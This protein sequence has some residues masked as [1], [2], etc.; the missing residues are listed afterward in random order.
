MQ[1]L[2]I[3]SMVL[4]AA[5]CNGTLRNI[6]CRLG[7]RFPYVQVN[8]CRNGHDHTPERRKFPE[9]LPLSSG[10]SYT[11]LGTETAHMSSK[12]TKLVKRP[13]LAFLVHVTCSDKVSLQDVEKGIQISIEASLMVTTVAPTLLTLPYTPSMLH[14]AML[15]MMQT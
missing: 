8:P 1:P 12:L 10:C 11:A 13:N 4:L 5:T 3:L 14:T 9:P 7:H 2:P 15:V 6:Q